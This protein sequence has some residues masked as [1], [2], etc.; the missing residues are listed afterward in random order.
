MRGRYLVALLWSQRE[1]EYHMFLEYLHGTNHSAHTSCTRGV[2]KGPWNHTPLF[3]STS[4]L[5]SY[6]SNTVITWQSIKTCCHTAAT[7]VQRYASLCLIASFLMTRSHFFSVFGHW[8]PA[9][10]LLP[11]SRSTP[12]LCLLPA[13]GQVCVDMRRGGR[14][15]LHAAYHNRLH[16]HE[17]C[18]VE[19]APVATEDIIWDWEEATFLSCSFLVS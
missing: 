8:Y 10:S 12:S 13:H 5:T 6:S 7:A 2:S 16:W 3:T 4:L 17:D 14:G 19:Q 18:S 9:E 11:C 15:V 1:G